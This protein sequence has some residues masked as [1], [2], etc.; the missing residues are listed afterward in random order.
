MKVGDTFTHSSRCQI[1][2]LYFICQVSMLVQGSFPS[3][4]SIEVSAT[5]LQQINIKICPSLALVS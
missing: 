3:T 1:T 2:I 4:L 5:L